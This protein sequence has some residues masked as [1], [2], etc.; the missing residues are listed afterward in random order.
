M[1]G[2]GV[3]RSRVRDAL[4]VGD[5][6]VVDRAVIVVVALVAVAACS[7]GSQDSPE[8][9]LLPGGSPGGLGDLQRASGDWWLTTGVVDGSELVAPAGTRALLS[10]NGDELVSVSPCTGFGTITASENGLQPETTNPFIGTS[11][12]ITL[13]AEHQLALHEA[14]GR[15]VSA[16]VA[17]RALILRGDGVELRYEP[18]TPPPEAVFDRDWTLVSWLPTL[19]NELVPAVAEAT[20]RFNRDGTFEG[21][22]GCGRWFGGTWEPE[23]DGFRFPRFDIEAPC[24]D[25]KSA[26]V[27]DQHGK[28]TALGVGARLILSDDQLYLVDGTGIHDRVSFIFE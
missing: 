13:I 26:E 16:E 17:G 12:C 10:I 7:T 4:G 8:G 19:S 6:G 18:L 28:L 2:G 23:L 3:S 22:S 24:P 25:T 15:V 21:A 11:G 20:L 27:I 9:A 5:T 14:L 1:P